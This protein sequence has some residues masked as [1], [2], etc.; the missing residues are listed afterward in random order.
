MHLEASVPRD[1]SEVITGHEPR[2]CETEIYTTSTNILKRIYMYVLFQIS[3]RM[4]NIHTDY[5]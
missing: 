3:D 2:S 1:M 4:V 5:D